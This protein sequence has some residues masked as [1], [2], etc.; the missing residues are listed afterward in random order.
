ML[1]QKIKKGPFTKTDY[2]FDEEPKWRLIG[3]YIQSPSRRNIPLMTRSSFFT[4]HI[5]LK[6]S[7]EELLSAMDKGTTYEIRRAER[8]GVTADA[9]GNVEDFIP[10]FNAFA[11]TK[12]IEGTDLNYMKYDKSMVITRA[13]HGDDL[14]VMHAYVED[15]KRGRLNMSASRLIGEDEDFKKSRALIGYANRY[16]HYQDILHF[17]NSG[18]GIYDF[19]GYAKDTNEKAMAGINKFK[20][21]FGGEVVEEFNY[22][23]RLLR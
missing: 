1:S 15:D 16:L 3:G 22:H 4:I 13:F 19:G 2:W 11:E 14:L 23:P 21:G 6:P 5:D 8:E 9:D 18:K 17:K 7:E 20:L 12:G 10:F